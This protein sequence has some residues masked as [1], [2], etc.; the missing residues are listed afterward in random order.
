MTPATLT[1]TLGVVSRMSG[2][3]RIVSVGAGCSESHYFP[4]QVFVLLA[5]KQPEEPKVPDA[6]TCANGRE[7]PEADIGTYHRFAD[8]RP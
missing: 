8:S 7:V 6:A 3:S 1:Q 4:E 5:A 2:L